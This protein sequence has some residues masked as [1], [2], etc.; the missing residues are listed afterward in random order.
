M[1]KRGLKRLYTFLI[2]L[3]LYAPIIVLIV[4]SFLLITSK[5]KVYGLDLRFKW[6]I[7]LFK[8]AEILKS[9]VLYIACGSTFSTYTLQL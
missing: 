1:V 6:Y 4:F 2:F 9:I 8:D 7:E 3:F 5:V